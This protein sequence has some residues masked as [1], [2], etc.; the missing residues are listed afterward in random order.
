[1]SDA[2]L[3]LE[4]FDQEE[5]QAQPAAPRPGE[6]SPIAAAGSDAHDDAW[7]KPALDAD[8]SAGDNATDTPDD[9]EQDLSPEP[10]LAS[11]ANGSA[12]EHE[13]PMPD[14]GVS[15]PAPA[16]DEP[17]AEMA[18]PAPLLLVSDPDPDP[19]SLAVS[20]NEPPH[21]AAE[22]AA[23]PAEHVIE[24]SPIFSALDA[25]DTAATESQHLTGP[26]IEPA[27]FDIPLP[28]APSLEDQLLTAA[29]PPPG[30]AVTDDHDLPLP[31]VGPSAA[32]I[33]EEPP[34][35][36]ERLRNEA[37][38]AKIAEE[39]NAT[40]EALESLK[41]MLNHK[42][43]LLEPI[44]A[45]PPP[46]PPPPLSVQPAA[47][48]PFSPTYEQTYEPTYE[49]PALPAAPTYHQRSQPVTPPPLVPLGPA[50]ELGMF[51]PRAPVRG[52]PGLGGFLAGFALSWV[53]GAMLYAYLT[54]MG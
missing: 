19:D 29:E 51:A 30:E 20:R 11:V 8:A 35:P 14:L 34:R 53:F 21:P 41:R 54:L 27:Q 10:N 37:A 44:P 50:A 12:A 40:A 16:S 31:E 36:A 3:P 28:Q 17:D 4:I 13:Q 24:V 26:F 22:H 23:P 6:T 32:P 25:A 46:A 9:L 38:A 47:P 48:P 49:R 1:M 2:R 18:Q 52:R 33:D 15:E 45:P 7:P 42:L 43:P 5:Q 39:A